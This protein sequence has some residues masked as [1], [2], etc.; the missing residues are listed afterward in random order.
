MFSPCFLFPNSVG[1]QHCTSLKFKSVLCSR[2]AE[3]WFCS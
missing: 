1:V 2:I 3:L